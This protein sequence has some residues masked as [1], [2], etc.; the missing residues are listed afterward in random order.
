MFEQKEYNKW[1]LAPGTESQLPM[2][3]NNKKIAFEKMLHKETY[4][5]TQEKQ[6][7]ACVVFLLLNQFDKTFKKQGNRLEN[8]FI[9]LKDK[10]SVVM[11]DAN[12][13][14]KMFSLIIDKI[15]NEKAKEKEDET[16]E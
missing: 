15:E 11:G 14:L 2:F 16:K 3:Q 5:L 1:S 4:L 8:Y 7:I 9:Q 12:D 10:C 13:L 6:R